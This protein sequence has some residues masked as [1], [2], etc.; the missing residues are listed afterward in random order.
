MIKVNVLFFATMRSL[1][2]KKNEEV[3]LP[4]GA[5]INDLKDELI[6]RYPDGK[7]AIK[8]MLA[9]I[10]HVFSDAETELADGDEVALF[11]H[12]SGG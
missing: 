4:D 6:A 8:S 9:V 3:E 12:V 2:G 1:A 5:R 7:L 10:N 11:P